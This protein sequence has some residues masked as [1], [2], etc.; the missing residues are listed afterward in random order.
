MAF[1]CWGADGVI[2]SIEAMEGGRWLG[3]SVCGKG[4]VNKRL[5]GY[6]KEDGR[7]RIRRVN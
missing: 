2:P 3:G 5:G 7:R 6:G 1:S 4:W